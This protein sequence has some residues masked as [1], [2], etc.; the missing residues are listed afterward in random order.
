VTGQGI[1]PPF[2]P[3]MALVEARELLRG[4]ADDGSTCPC[5]TQRVKVYRRNL[6]SVAARAVLA[7]YEECG[8]GWGHMGD[9]ARKRLA[10]VAH[11]GGYLVLAQ[12]WGLIEE[13]TRKRSDGGRQGWWR[14]TALG[15][16]WLR[17]EEPVPKYARVYNGRCLGLHGDLVTVRDALGEGFDFG[18]LVRAVT[19]RTE[20]L[21]DEPLFPPRREAA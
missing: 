9:V 8:R 11:Q 17:G 7:L 3:A 14:V 21:H 1:Q 13:D 10:D 4:L 15:E 20:R 5:C 19:P 12:H 16:L 18:H 2:R 6:T